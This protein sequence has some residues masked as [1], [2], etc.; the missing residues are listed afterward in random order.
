MPVTAECWGLR[1]EIIDKN[2]LDGDTSD[3]DYYVYPE[4]FKKDLCKGFDA[5]RIARILRDINALVLTDSDR[6]E[7]RLTTKAR[8]PR[9]GERAKSV[10]RI[11]NSMLF[12]D[13]EN[14]EAA[15][16]NAA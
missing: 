12:G 8:L 3:A 11:R 14:S 7:G 4:S 15:I 6:K 1:R 16:Q 13:R 5:N 2:P 9:L 10:Y